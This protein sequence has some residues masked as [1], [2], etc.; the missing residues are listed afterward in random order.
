MNVDTL[1]ILGKFNQL[2]SEPSADN[3]EAAETTFTNRGASFA[4]FQEWA[5]KRLLHPSEMYF[6]TGA[7]D[8]VIVLAVGA[9]AEA[10][11]VAAIV[12]ALGPALNAEV[13][14]LTV[15]GDVTK[16]LAEAAVANKNIGHTNMG[17]GGPNG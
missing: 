4:K 2:A 13:T 14:T 6:T 16:V 10:V 7:Y 17:E 5:N 3:G 8:F 15:V 1:V 12:A 11:D 9:G